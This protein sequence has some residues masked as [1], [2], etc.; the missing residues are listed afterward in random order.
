VI[1]L[2]Q[3]APAESKSSSDSM[4]FKNILF[5]VDFSPQSQQIVP[6]VRDMVNRCRSRL[7]LLHAA[8]VYGANGFDP[9]L[10]EGLVYFDEIL[11]REKDSL[12]AFQSGHFPSPNVNSTLEKGSPARVIADYVKV[13]PVDL[14]M[15]P[16]HGCGTFRA[17]LLG[18]VTEKVIHDTHCPVW[19]S[20]HT[21]KIHNP[22][23]PYRLIVCAID[24]LESSIPVIRKAGEIAAAFESLLVL[25]H[26]VKPSE[27]RTESEI[28]S[29][30]EQLGWSGEVSVPISI[31]A[32]DIVDVVTKTAVREGADL[33]IIGRGRSTE[34]LGSIRSHVFGIIRESPCPVLTV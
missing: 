30:L 13:N 2:A 9:S 3:I 6:A 31:E 29:R 12:A 15:M 1:T 24:E 18:S 5:P 21:E 14:I 19:T 10:A 26:A 8:E 20:V 22:V 28:R 17:A 25:T 11:Q 27:K 4:Q 32:G 7:T 23:Y 33:V 34:V 16:T